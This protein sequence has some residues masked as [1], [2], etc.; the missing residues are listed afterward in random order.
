[1]TPI[2]AE[3][4]TS[5]IANQSAFATPGN[6]IGTDAALCLPRRKPSFPAGSDDRQ[7]FAGAEQWLNTWPVPL[8]DDPRPIVRGRPATPGET[9]HVDFWSD[10]SFGAVP[11][12]DDA[13]NAQY[14]RR[15]RYV[16]QTGETLLPLQSLGM[17]SSHIFLDQ[18]TPTPRV[19][20]RRVPLSDDAKATGTQGT[21]DQDAAIQ[22]AW[23]VE[24]ERP[25]YPLRAAL[26]QLQATSAETITYWLNTVCQGA[27]GDDDAGMS[28]YPRKPLSYFANSLTHE[29]VGP[30]PTI[31]IGIG[32]T[33]WISD[34]G[35]LV[36][37]YKRP[38]LWQSWEANVEPPWAG[39]MSLPTYTI[40]GPAGVGYV[41][42]VGQMFC[43]GAVAGILREAG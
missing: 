32:S 27:P 20:W 8:G 15:Y 14:P 37:A 2:P 4:D 16:T 9:A 5:L 35:P 11:D 12:G 39:A 24:Q 18:Y 25:A 33:V 7:P 29:T 21:P 17:T 34:Q 1:M 30:P 41:V 10:T 22:G 40:A 26:P 6:F 38:N 23:R 31:G 43:A 36:P 3:D 13:G 28:V 42:L 19:L